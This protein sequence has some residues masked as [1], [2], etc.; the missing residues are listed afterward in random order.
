MIRIVFGRGLT[1]RITLPSLLFMVWI[2]L[3]VAMLPW[4]LRFETIML[5]LVI[6]YPVMVLAG[7]IADS[8]AGERERSTLE[9][10]LLSPVPDWI[11]VSSKAL[12]LLI[13][14]FVQQGLSLAVLGAIAP[15]VDSTVAPKPLWY[16]LALYYGLITFIT[17]INLGLI[18]SWSSPTVQIAQQ[19]MLYA[20]LVILIGIVAAQLIFVRHP[21]LALTLT[22]PGTVLGGGLVAVGTIV[23]ALSGFRRGRLLVQ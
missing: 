23:A 12:A 21:V 17:V 15:L 16:A 9:L 10:L 22:A 2:V 18:V 11:I 3:N 7:Y 5:S 13:V 14:A 4:I 6:G 8:F 20:V 19:T 1:R